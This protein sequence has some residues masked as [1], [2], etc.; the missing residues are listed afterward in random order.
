MSR[1]L[2]LRRNL[3]CSAIIF[4]VMAGM[5]VNAARAAEPTPP[6]ILLLFADQLHG[7]ALGCTGNKQSH[8]PTLDRLAREGVLF[9]DNYSNNPLCA[10]YR[11]I[12]MTGRYSSQNNVQKNPKPSGDNG[13]KG[14]RTM[15][16]CL[17][18]SGYRTSYVG[19]WHLGSHGNIAVPP[20]LRGGFTDFIGYQCFNDFLHDVFF[21]DEKGKKIEHKN[22]RTDA[23][24]D[25]AIERLEK[26]GTKPFALFVSYQNPH[27]PLQP[28]PEFAALYKDVTITRRPNCVEVDPYTST[29]SPYHKTQDDPCYIAY[30]NNLDEYLRRY[31]AMVAQLDANVGR[32]LKRLDELGLASNTVVIFTSDHGDMAGSHGLTNKRY[33][34]EESVR[35]PLIV[36]MPGGAQ[37]KRVSVPVSAIDLLPTC[38]GLAGAPPLPGAEGVDLTP[39]LRGSAELAPRP[40]FSEQNKWIMVREGDYK[41][42]VARGGQ[43][44]MELFNLK[45]DPYEM[46]NLVE[47]AAHTAIRNRLRELTVEWIR[48]VRPKTPQ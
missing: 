39:V 31:Y 22:H 48:H 30:H 4:T 10:P 21:F 23:T 6:N 43:I 29:Y 17:N 20:E 35:T 14:Q 26:M 45:D 37:G 12:L 33:S 3:L 32:L 7:F 28:S 46:K 25:I 13:I 47:D 38:L 15:A 41:L 1:M 11:A 8:T 2:S 40:V 44:P 27:Y 34:Y 16:D 36:R 42:V 5:G 19:K 9:T 24:T 18:A